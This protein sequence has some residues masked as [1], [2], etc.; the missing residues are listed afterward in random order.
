MSKMRIVTEKEGW[1]LTMSLPSSTMATRWPLKGEG[2]RTMT[3]S[4]F[5]YRVLGSSEEPYVYIYEIL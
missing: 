3:S 1:W 5:T 4:M 2:Y